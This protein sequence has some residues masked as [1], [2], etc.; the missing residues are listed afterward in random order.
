MTVWEG[1][2]EAKKKNERRTKE[3]NNLFVLV[4]TLK[5]IFF[6][7]M[8]NDS[9]SNDADC[10][11]MHNLHQYA[12]R[13]KEINE[14]IKSACVTLAPEL[15]SIINAYAE[16]HHTEI[17]NCIDHISDCD[18][19]KCVMY[20]VDLLSQWETC[21][22]CHAYV[23]KFSQRERMYTKKNDRGV[24]E[25]WNLFTIARCHSC[26]CRKLKPQKTVLC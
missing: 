16:V 4:K 20:H 15:L 11:T 10:H 12:C 19:K 13:F 1:G 6:V 24:L 26:R 7:V 23:G 2:K 22:W 25:T 18:D 5:K 3:R 8:E 9:K 14:M 21:E 17:D